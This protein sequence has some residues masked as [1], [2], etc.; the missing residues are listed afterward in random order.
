[1]SFI[2]FYPTPPRN[3]P[4]PAADE[5]IGYISYVKPDR[6]DYVIWKYFCLI[7]FFKG[8]FLGALA[9][10]LS[11]HWINAVLSGFTSVPVG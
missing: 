10:I 7:L 3:G 9:L 6:S 5:S 11:A 2:R 1:M 4:V 8:L